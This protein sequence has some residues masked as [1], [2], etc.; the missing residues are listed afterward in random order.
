MPVSNLSTMIEK[1]SAGTTKLGPGTVLKLWF[2]LTK[3]EKRDLTLMFTTLKENGWNPD[4]IENLDTPNISEDDRNKLVIL[5]LDLLE[6]DSE[7]FDLI[8]T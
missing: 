8:L 3:A 5:V 4:S 7:I 1:I 6:D 2:S